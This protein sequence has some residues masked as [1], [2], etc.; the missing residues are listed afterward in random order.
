MMRSRD[1]ITFAALLLT[2]LTVSIATPTRS[3]SGRGIEG[4][5]QGL[6]QGSL[7]LVLHV[8]RT[9]AGGFH[10]SLDSPDQ[11]A[12]GLVIDSLTFAGDSLW[13]EMRALQASFTATMSGDT[14]LVGAWKQGGTTLL[15][16]L[17]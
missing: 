4:T 9:P 11:G 3:Q 16:T 7:R 13:F 2:L 12:R 17:K 15:L 10:A 8:D 14:A 6:I 1:G 5:W